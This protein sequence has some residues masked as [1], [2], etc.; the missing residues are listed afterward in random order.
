MASVYDNIF[1]LTVAETESY[2]DGIVVDTLHAHFRKLRP[3][4]EADSAIS[5]PTR[6][7]HANTR[8]TNILFQ[9]FGA[10]CID[11][12]QRGRLDLRE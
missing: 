12:G 8:V 3:N 9:T 4:F 5:S 7:P 1:S 2:A 11:R 10:H 6:R